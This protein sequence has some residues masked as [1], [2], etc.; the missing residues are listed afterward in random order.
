M[1]ILFLFYIYINDIQNC[2]RIFFILLFADNT[3]VFFYSSDSSLKTLNEILQSEI[4]KVAAWMVEY[5][6]TDC[7]YIQKGQVYPI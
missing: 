3:N 5:I 6:L 7:P 2:S 1:K 4:N